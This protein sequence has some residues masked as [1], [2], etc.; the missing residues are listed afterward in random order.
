MYK[1]VNNNLDEAGGG[2]AITDNSNNNLPY[3]NLLSTLQHWPWGRPQQAE[4]MTWLEF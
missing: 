1:K 2:H 4:T 3:S